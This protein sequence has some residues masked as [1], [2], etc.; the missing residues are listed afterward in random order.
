MKTRTTIKTGFLKF[1]LIVS[2]LALPLLSQQ[3]G[4]KVKTKKE[5]AKASSGEW[6]EY[7]GHMNW[8]EATAKCASIGMR[9]P[10]IAELKAAYAAGVTELWRKDGDHYW[11]ST[12]YGTVFAYLLNV[13]DG[14]VTYYYRTYVRHVRCLR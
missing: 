4:S 6:S 1:G 7:Q 12:P 14:I 2:M 9:L 5:P 13:Y 8:N 3:A 10:T 11:S